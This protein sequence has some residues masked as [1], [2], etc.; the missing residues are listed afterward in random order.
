MVQKV[1][2]FLFVFPALQVLGLV[3]SD[4]LSRHL[5][6]LLTLHRCTKT[7]CSLQSFR[8]AAY[9]TKSGRCWLIRIRSPSDNWDWICWSCAAITAYTLLRGSCLSQRFQGRLASWITKRLIPF[10][11]LGVLCWFIHSIN[12]TNEELFIQAA[13]QYLLVYIYI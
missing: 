5:P 12:K 6:A 13:N 1:Q 10:L 3:L 2:S 7:E 11:G 8:E 9:H 4:D